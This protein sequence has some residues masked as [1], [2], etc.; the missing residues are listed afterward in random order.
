MRESPGA[1]RLT[2]TDQQHLKHHKNGHH[3]RPP[4]APSRRA[5]CAALPLHHVPAHLFRHFSVPSAPA[6]TAVSIRDWAL[7]EGH[8]FA[9]GLEAE[10]TMKCYAMQA[11]EGTERDS[12]R[13]MRTSHR[14]R[15]ARCGMG[16][17]TI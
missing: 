1:A 3:V 4:H 14:A 11:F 2:E 17:V 5:D 13:A 6:P 9:G 16:R 10:G 7:E 8:T 15:L 12:V